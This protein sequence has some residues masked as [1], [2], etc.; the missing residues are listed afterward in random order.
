MNKRHFMTTLCIS[1][2][3]LNIHRNALTIIGGGAALINEIREET[4]DIDVL[5][6][7]ETFER[8]T[9]CIGKDKIVDLPACND[10]P[11]C[12]TITYKGVDYLYSAP[13]QGDYDVVRYRG[14]NVLS[15]VGLLKYKKQLNRSK[16]QVDIE[17]LSTLIGETN[18]L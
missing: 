13:M 5:V 8:I 18:E 2:D 15:K 7:A 6:D 3:K 16:D 9:W 1:C 14:F 4:N 11:A 10:M 12:Q 17:K